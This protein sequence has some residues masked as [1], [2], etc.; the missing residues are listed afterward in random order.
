M[1]VLVK[2][3]GAGCGVG[4]GYIIYPPVAVVE[5]HLL[6]QDV[7]K[8]VQHGGDEGWELVATGHGAQ[9]QRGEAHVGD[10]SYHNA[11]EQAALEGTLVAIPVYLNYY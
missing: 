2:G 9:E 6:H 7:H 5:A 3:H 1:Q 10:K 8:D 11:I 4:G